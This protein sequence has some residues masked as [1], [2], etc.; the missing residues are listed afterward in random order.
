ELDRQLTRSQITSLL[1]ALLL[2]FLLLWA[3][4]KSIAG[5]LISVTPIA[6]TILVNFGVM[7]YLGIPLDTATMMIASIAIGIGIDYTIHFTSRFRLELAKQ[8]SYGSPLCLF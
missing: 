4:F 8:A 6:L 7:S 2:V 1:I 5:G 3:Q